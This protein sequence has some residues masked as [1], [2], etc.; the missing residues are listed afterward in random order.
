MM[1]LRLNRY[2]S[3][4][5]KKEKSNHENN[6]QSTDRNIGDFFG[7]THPEYSFTIS[8][9]YREI[10]QSSAMVTNWLTSTSQ[11]NEPLPEAP[12]STCLPVEKQNKRFS[13]STS[14]CAS[15]FA[16]GLK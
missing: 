10:R 14:Q 9:K 11:S 12:E 15:V 8:V 16:L 7:L 1:Y 2:Y 3:K 5:T 4:L 6:N 13:V